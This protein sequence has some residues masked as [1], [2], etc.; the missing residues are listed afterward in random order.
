MIN[1]GDPQ[2]DTTK[3]GA[4]INSDHAQKVLC[5]IEK[6][7]QQVVSLLSLNQFL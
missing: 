4:M 2:C 7:V 6:A 1:P 5:Y 3:T